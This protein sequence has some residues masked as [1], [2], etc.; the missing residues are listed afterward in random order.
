M[1]DLLSRIL[2]LSGITSAR[3]LYEDL[4]RKMSVSGSLHEEPAGTISAEGCVWKS[5]HATLPAFRAMDTRALLRGLHLEIRKRNF[6]SIPRDGHARS[7]QRVHI[8][9]TCFRSTAPATKP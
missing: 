1:Q 3:S 6:T 8:S 2:G 5:E 4:S 7:P 9:E